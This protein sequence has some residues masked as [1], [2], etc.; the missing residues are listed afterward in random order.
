MTLR[1]RLARFYAV[2][3]ALMLG[4]FAATLWAILEAAEANESPLVSALEPP[5]RTGTNVLIALGASLPVAIAVA[6]GGAAVIARRGLKPLD[7]V[8]ALAGRVGA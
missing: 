4:A 3:I 2:T 5:D 8:V 6:V 1:G 7:D